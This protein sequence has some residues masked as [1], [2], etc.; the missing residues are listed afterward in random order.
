MC[1]AH[2]RVHLPR[3]AVAGDVADHV[4]LR[5][6]ARHRHDAGAE[7]AECPKQLREIGIA[8]RARL[9]RQPRQQRRLRDVRR[10]D[11]RPR[12]Q[13]A[14]RRAH[15]LVDLRVIDAVVRHDRVNDDERVGRCDAVDRLR[16]QLRLLRRSQIAGVDAVDAHALALPVARNGQHIVREVSKC[17][18]GELPRVRAEHG[19]RDTRAL[20]AGSRDDRQRHGQRALAEP[21][22][23]VDGG[24]ALERR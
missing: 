10:D 22:Q 23:V 1:R 8:V 3:A 15:P 2:A 14:K 11:I 12:E 5:A 16:E 19:R 24:D 20:N 18:A 7:R 13:A 4:R 6:H 21:G 17:P 9:I